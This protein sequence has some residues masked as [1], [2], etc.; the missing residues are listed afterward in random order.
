M[1]ILTIPTI[2]YE[3]FVIATLL[4]SWTQV[5]D[6]SGYIDFS[7]A[8]SFNI[9]VWMFLLASIVSFFVVLFFVPIWRIGYVSKHDE[10]I[11]FLRLL[12]AIMTLPMLG[13]MASQLFG[14][15]VNLVTIAGTIFM[16]FQLVRQHNL[17][18]YLL[19]TQTIRSIA[20]AVISMCLASIL[21]TISTWTPFLDEKI[22][23]F[24]LCFTVFYLPINY[25]IELTPYKRWMILAKVLIF[26]LATFQ[27]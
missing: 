25:L 7:S 8:W 14:E 3:I 13:M 20:S 15:R 6:V 17:K 5:Q 10:K 9:Y 12:L 23:L 2:V 11:F 4:L 1:K 26:W 19:V 16:M 27:R 21:W 18:K 22:W 24:A